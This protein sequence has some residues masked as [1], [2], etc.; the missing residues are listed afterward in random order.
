MNALEKYASK[1][2]L[3]MGLSNMLMGLAS[4]LGG[5]KPMGHSPLGGHS[6]MPQPSTSIAHRDDDSRMLSKVLDSMA[7]QAISL[8]KKIDMGHKLPSWAEYKVYKAGDCMKSATA[9]TFSLKPKVTIIIKSGP[10]MGS[11]LPGNM[12]KKAWA[13]LT[14]EGR[15]SNFY[16]E[17]L[18]P[19]ALK[20]VQ[21]GSFDGT[22]LSYRIFRPNAKVPRKHG[23]KTVGKIEAHAIGRKISRL[24]AGG[25]LSAS[26]KKRLLDAARKRKAG[27]L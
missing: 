24:L 8:K 9:S 25:K 2:K 20:A 3:A 12:V 19:E 5:H 13:S 14:K 22:A 17:L 15:L 27:W 1:R 23:K 16:K 21:K 10:S 4:K 11:P 26:E 6:M 7:A 18:T